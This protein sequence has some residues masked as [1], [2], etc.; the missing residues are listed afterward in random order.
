MIEFQLGV[1]PPRAITAAAFTD[2]DHDGTRH[3]VTTRQIFRIR[4]ITL[5]EALA[6]FVQQI[7]AFTAA[8]FCDQHARAGDTGGVELPHLHILHRHASADSHTDAVTGIDV[9]VS[10]G[11]INTA[12]A[13][14]GQY[15]C[16]GFKVNHFTGFDTQCGTT[17]NRAVSVL[18]QSNAYH[19]EKMVV[20]F[21]RFC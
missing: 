16:A 12:C 13:A 15:G 6:V 5:H 2:F 4:G 10:S 8:A 3:H 19:S 11:L 18:Y 1:R 9:G 14:G 20:W 17:D 21:F 7:A